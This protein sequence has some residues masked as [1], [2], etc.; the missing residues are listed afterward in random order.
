MSAV[1]AEEAAIRQQIGK[2]IEGLRTKDLDVLR[3]PYAPDVVSFDVEPPLQHV[4]IDAKLANWARV[5]E[6][7]EK[8]DYELRDLTLTIGGDVAFGYAFGRLSGTMKNGVATTGMWVRVTYGL[9]RIDGI[10]RIVHDQVSVPFDILSGTGVTDL[11][12]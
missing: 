2:V 3:E 11:E 9:R 1:A 8:V 5:F 12:P 10:W 6:V 4:G 7:F